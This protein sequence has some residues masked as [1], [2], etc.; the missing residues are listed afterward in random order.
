MPSLEGDEQVLNLKKMKQTS[1]KLTLVY[2][3]SISCKQCE[4]SIEK[5]KELERQFSAEL[6]IITVHMPRSEQDREL[7]SI[8]KKAK[9]LHLEHPIILDYQLRITDA[10]DNRIVPG[11]YLFDQQKMLRFYRAGFTT[12]KMLE[13]KIRRLI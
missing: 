13:H 3:W 10:F 2:F 4:E 5:L 12:T 1:G 8:K 7:E 11:Y 9:Q 6:A